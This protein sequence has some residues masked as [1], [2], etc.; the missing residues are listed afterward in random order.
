MATSVVIAVGGPR[1]ASLASSSQS[2]LVRERDW[3]D[4]GMR[5]PVLV[6]NLCEW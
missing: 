6:E 5:R 2:Y 1:F 3:L 4:S